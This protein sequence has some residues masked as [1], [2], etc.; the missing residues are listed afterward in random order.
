MGDT[1][2]DM[3]FMFQ[4]VARRL[5]GAT[6]APATTNVR[7]RPLLL[8]THYIRPVTASCFDPPPNVES[9]LVGFRPKP[10]REL[11]AL[12]G[13][14]KQFFSS[15]RRVSRKKR[16]M[17]KNNLRAVCDDEVIAAALEDLGRDEKTRAQQLTMDEYVRLF[18][19]VRLKGLGKESKSSRIE[20]AESKSPRVSAR[21]GEGGEGYV[22]ARGPGGGPRRFRRRRRRR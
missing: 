7:A 5:I 6:P 16:K 14:E 13:T 1:F 10:R 20:S 22:Q 11:P 18:N 15:S 12:R 17:L 21:G 2:E 19:F 8:R 4:E 9:C 3:V